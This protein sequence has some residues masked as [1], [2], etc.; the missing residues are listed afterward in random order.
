MMVK[1][2]VEL[3]ALPNPAQVHRGQHCHEQQCHHDDSDLAPVEVEPGVE[4]GGEEPGCRR[5]RGDAGT[6]HHEGH[7]EGHELHAE[8]LVHVER[9]TGRLRVLRHQ[10]QVTERGDGGD[11]ERGEERNPRCPTDFGGD[12]TGQRVHAGAQDVADDEQQQ[13]AGAHYSPQF[14]LLLDGFGLTHGSPFCHTRATSLVYRCQHIDDV[15][16]RCAGGRAR[17]VTVAHQRRH[18]RAVDGTHQ[19]SEQLRPHRA[20]GPFDDLDDG[21]GALPQ[22]PPLDVPQAGLAGAGDVALIA[23]DQLLADPRFRRVTDQQVHQHLGRR[24][25]APAPTRQHGHPLPQLLGLA[26]T[27]VLDGVGDQVVEGGKV[28]GRRRQRQPRPAGDG[29]MPHGVEP[30]FAEQVRGGA[31]QRIPPTLS[32]GSDR[33]RHH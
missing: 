23:G 21:I 22:N 24:L 16:Q 2:D 26:R 1:T 12:V 20:A 33:C 28:V 9:R 27:G 19:R 13:Q 5:G 3:D 32:L 10:L 30:A 6:H 14:W 8:S 15:D 31:D 29:A 11:Q 17:T 18:H 4:V 25:G 7:Q